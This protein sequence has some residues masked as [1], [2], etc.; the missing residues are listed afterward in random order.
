MAPVDRDLV[1]GDRYPGEAAGLALGTD[2]G[3]VAVHADGSEIFQWGGLDGRPGW[4]TRLSSG[5]SP[6]AGQG[7]TVGSSRCVADNAPG[8][9]VVSATHVVCLVPNGVAPLPDA[10]LPPEGLPAMSIVVLDAADGSVTAQWASPGAQSIAVFSGLVVV[11]SGTATESVI[12]GRD[13]ATGAERWSFGYAGP[14]VTA[15]AVTRVQRASGLIAADTSSGQRW[16][17]ATDGTPV[18]DGGVEASPSGG[19]RVDPL[20]QRLTF[21]GPSA[22]TGGTQT[23]L[24]APNAQTAGDQTF[25]GVPVDVTVDDASIPGLM[26]TV[27]PQLYGGDTDSGAQR[28]ALD[29]TTFSGSSGTSA[30]VVRGRVYVL[31]GPRVI[32]VEGHTGK[33]LWRTKDEDGVRP[34]TVMTDGRHVLVG[35]DAVS[36]RGNPEL[37][38]YDFSDGREAFRTELPTGISHVGAAGGTLFGFDDHDRELVTLH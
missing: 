2:G 5:R 23:T 4:S 22:A 28:W 26:L 1:V 12:D 21:S 3:F 35:F 9:P 10:S 7:V 6:E 24:L 29:G 33:E 38:A 14:Q 18:R 17:F 8:T 30:I 31:A 19:W 20:T 36:A 37:I 27:G 15:N 34:T 25:D 32:A 11:G 16:V 13:M